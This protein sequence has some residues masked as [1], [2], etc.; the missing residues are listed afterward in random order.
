MRSA[1]AIAGALSVLS[2][3][4]W[5]FAGIPLWASIDDSFGRGYVLFLIHGAGLFAGAMAIQDS[6]WSKT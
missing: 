6:L 4:L 3:L 5:A 1:C 2:I